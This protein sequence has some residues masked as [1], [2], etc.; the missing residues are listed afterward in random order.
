MSICIFVAGNVLADPIEVVPAQGPAISTNINQREP[1]KNKD[2]E[3]MLPQ[4]LHPFNPDD[5]WQDL[6]PDMMP[7][8]PLNRTLTPRERKLLDRR[9]NWV[10][11]TPEELMSGESTEELLGMK[12]Y[13]KDGTEKEP[14]N[15]ME[16]YYEHLV[17]SSR[18]TV[19]NQFDK[20]SDSGNT[21]TNTVVDG[22]EQN[23]DNVH[24]FDS[25]F[26]SRPSEVFQPMQ[27]NTFSDVFGARPDST[28][29]DAETI[30]AEKEQKMHMESFKQ[31]WD[32]D[33]SS[34]PADAF[35][36]A[37]GSSASG[38]NSFPSMQPVLGTVSPS[39][40]GS[41]VHASRA[42]AQPAPTPKQTQPPRPNFT[43]PQRPF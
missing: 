13:N 33:Q 7:P 11:M 16:R 42:V 30:Q 37:P 1:T 29:P 3:V 10:F 32:M 22:G 6:T 43:I 41:S 8:Q 25:P 20:D 5:S 35:N 14:K 17:E 31:L 28:I 9:R 38:V 24:P 2:F 4:A 19:T 27:P 40:A 34:A 12:E 39:L 21:L 23:G 26:T 18:N 36:S 15:A